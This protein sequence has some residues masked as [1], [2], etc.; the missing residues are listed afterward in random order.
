MVYYYCILLQ[1]WWY[2]CGDWRQATQSVRIASHALDRIS[3]L[4]RRYIWHNT[5]AHTFSYRIA[6]QWFK[7]YTTFVQCRTEMNRTRTEI[8]VFDSAPHITFMFTNLLFTDIQV[9]RYRYI[10]V[11]IY[12][13]DHTHSDKLFQVPLKIPSQNYRQYTIYIINTFRS[14]A[15]FTQDLGL[16]WSWQ[17]LCTSW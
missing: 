11:D 3:S 1:R 7:R 8:H 9:K 13:F 10:W 12:E 4:Y 5:S 15:I 2:Q 6:E 17:C 14:P 16:C